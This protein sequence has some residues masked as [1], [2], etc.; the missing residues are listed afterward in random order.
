MR[1]TIIVAGIATLFCLTGVVRNSLAA[2]VPTITLVQSFLLPGT[3]STSLAGIN[4]SKEVVGNAGPNSAGMGFQFELLSG[5]IINDIAF[6]GATSFTNATGINDSG[7]VAGYYDDQPAFFTGFFLQNGVYTSFSEGATC[8][9]ALCNT[10]I[11]GI[12]NL[13]DF[14]G[15][16]TPVNQGTMDQA[17]VDIGGVFTNVTVPS[18]SGSAFMTGIDNHSAKAVGGYYDVNN[19][20]HGLIYDVATK[21]LTHADF[22]GAFETF[23]GGINVK[24]AISG[25]EFDSL[26][27]LHA[28]VQACGG[29]WASYDFP[30]ALSTGA[31]G[32]NDNGIM[33][34]SYSDS[35]GN[36]H[37]L[38]L[39]VACVPAP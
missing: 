31:S 16:W 9:A 5:G 19:H 15:F 35:A 12:N 1:K 11:R 2:S 27:N 14:V 24:G 13:G 21:T 18:V 10:A 38:L 3:T 6:P 37:G 29:Q 34:G 26:G 30:G 4:N 28:I 20:Q 17:F 32:I 22:P 25:T 8:G 33:A 36:N 39:K 7:E 23:L